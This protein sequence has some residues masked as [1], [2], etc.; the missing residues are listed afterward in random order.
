SQIPE[1]QPLPNLL[2]GAVH[3]LLL[4]NHS[5]ELSAFYPNLTPLP[6]QPEEAFPDFRRFCLTHRDEII[7][8][9]RNRRVQTNEV[10]RCA[11]LFPAFSLIFDLAQKKPLSLI[12]IGTSAGLNLMWDHYS[13]SYGTDVTCGNT[14][15]LVK[16]TSTFRGDK[17]PM[18][19][20][21]LPTLSDRI[22][23]DLN[24]IDIHKP[25]DT[26]W[27]KA[28]IW[29]EHIERAR[30]LSNAIQVAQSQPLKLMSGDGIALLPDILNELSTET[31]LCIFHTHMLNQVP[32]E[33]RVQ[34][35]DFLV[36]YSK[37]RDIYRVS[38]E[39]IGTKYPQLEMAF[40]HQGRSTETLLA[41]CDAHA[42]WIEWLS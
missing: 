37:V 19:S 28:L 6:Q 7:H 14:G 31:T 22:G 38:C 23:V 29:P 36:D 40:F 33:T 8:L 4:Q 32:P 42:R 26:L 3:Y 18:L 39:W 34:L 16:I 24:V 21:S 9:L 15:S 30:L 5:H 35:L 1:G 10:S 12:E 41:Y 27:L 13:Y 20:A 2:F 25:E 17:R 11:Y